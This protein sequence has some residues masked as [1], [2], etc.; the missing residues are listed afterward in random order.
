MSDPCLFCRGAG[1]LMCG[2]R[3]GKA[4]VKRKPH[5][6]GAGL[7]SGHLVNIARGLHPTGQPMPDQG[8]KAARSRCGTCARR[9]VGKPILCLAVDLVLVRAT[10]P[11]CINYQPTE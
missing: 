4:P 10:M 8:T 1:C 3:S 2:A 6:F 7:P 11:A 9:Q 5:P